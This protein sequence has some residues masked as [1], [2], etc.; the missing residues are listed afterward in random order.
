M[1]SLEYYVV[2][3]TTVTIVGSAH[4][5][6][7]S[8]GDFS[9]WD[10]GSTGTAT[11]SREVAGGNP[12][13]FL[14]VTT[15]SGITVYGTAIKTDFSTDLALAGVTFE[16]KLDV[17]SGPGAQGQGQRILG[18][19]EQN[20]SVYGIDLGITGYPHSWD[21]LTFG[22]TFSDTSFPLLSGAGPATPDF[23]GGTTTFFG[24]AAGNSNSG[25]LTQY[26]DN[27]TLDVSIPAPGAILLGTFGA[28]LV[29][30]LR[31]RRTL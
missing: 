9:S 11:V 20:S 8:D 31:R 28:G 18:L 21:T 27:Y 1:K 19:V 15:V 6:F 25:T 7:I 17:F 4:G 29:G 26:Y 30:W 5:A 14:N 12:G 2:V 3:A 13:A 23:S 22:G 16:L 24:F 10:F